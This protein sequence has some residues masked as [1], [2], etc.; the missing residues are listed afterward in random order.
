[1]EPREIAPGI[2]GLGSYQVNWYLIEDGGKLSAVDAGLPGFARHLDNDLA[3]LALALP[4]IEAVVLTHSD[5]DHTGVAPVL[6]DAGA[7]VLIHAA[8]DATL[9][10]PGPKGGDASAPKILA[11]L[12]R[13][14]T[15]KILGHTL[16]HGGAKP[17]KVDGAETY[18]DGD[19]LDVPGR[20]R[21]LHTP[22]HTPGHCAL[23]AESRRVLFAGDALIDH[24]SSP[25]A[26]GRRSCRASRTSTAPRHCL[27][28][29]RWKRSTTRS[30]S[31]SSATASRGTGASSRPSNRRGASHLLRVRGPKAA[32]EAIAHAAANPEGPEKPL[33]PGLS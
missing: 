24:P 27:P 22:G 33:T 1:M 25:R 2:Y 15:L 32:H 18:S 8:D 5:G 10:K 12:W 14:S 30:T 9:R 13:P 16:K 31:C 3:Q 7:R 26:A 6:R 11:N 29:T 17:A 4:D 20:L 28:W 21:V 19:V 23:L